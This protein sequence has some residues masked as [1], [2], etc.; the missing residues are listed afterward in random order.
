[1]VLA[2]FIGIT[3]SLQSVQSA[4]QIVIIDLAN[5]SF[6]RRKRF[7]RDRLNSLSLHFKIGKWILASSPCM[8]KHITHEHF[9]ILVTIRYQ[10]HDEKY[11]R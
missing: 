2:Q 6:I 11:E 1:M 3:N 5:L 9:Y 7:L 10:S 8:V 4:Q